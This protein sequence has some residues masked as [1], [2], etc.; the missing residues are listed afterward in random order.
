M[1]DFSR[2]EAIKKNQMEIL[3]MKNTSDTNSFKEVDRTQQRKES[4]NLKTIQ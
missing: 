2:N 4:M 3:E 1:G